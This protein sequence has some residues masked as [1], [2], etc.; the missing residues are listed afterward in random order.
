MRAFIHSEEV[1]SNRCREAPTRANP[2]DWRRPPPHESC[3]A[4]TR[5]VPLPSRLCCHVPRRRRCLLPSGSWR[6]KNNS[7]S[8]YG[9]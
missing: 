7:L 5:P 2:L 9:D 6:G 4:V 8:R 1:R 3:S